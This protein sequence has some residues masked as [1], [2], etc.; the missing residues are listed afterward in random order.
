MTVDDDNTAGGSA[1]GKSDE[2]QESRETNGRSVGNLELFFDL[3]FVYAM[4]Q[5]THLMLSDIS[6]QGFGRGVLALLAL[7]W[8]WVCY[9]W[10]TNTFETARVIHTTLIILAMAAMLIAVIAMPTAFTTG[11]LVFGLALIVVRLINAGMFIASSSRDEAELASAIRRLVPGLLV[12]PVLIVAAAFVASPYRELLWV[13]AAVV[14]FGTPLKARISELRVVPSYFVERH[15]SV[16][17]IA[18]GETIVALGAGAHDDLRH[19]VVLGAVVLGVLISATLWWTYFG[20][21][22]GAEERMHRTP[23]V[24]RPRLARDALQLPAPA[25]RGRDHLLRRRDTGVGGTHRRATGAA[26]RP[27]S[28]LWGGTVLRRRGGLPMA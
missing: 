28:Y 17:I 3:T 6:W 11:A 12:G 5:V 14:D 7:W 25:P 23:A 1:G 26:A 15:G 24:D 9:A 8:A 16:I 13:A 4:S 19:P 22:A 10:L 2:S 18:L 21:T 27:R 20:L